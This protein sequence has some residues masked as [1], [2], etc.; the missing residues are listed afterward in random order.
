MPNIGRWVRYENGSKIPR[1]FEVN[2]KSFDGL[3]ATITWQCLKND[4]PG[5]ASDK[6]AETE[7]SWVRG[8]R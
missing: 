2:H 7:A 5:R 4:T 8:L 6:R 1:F 3:G